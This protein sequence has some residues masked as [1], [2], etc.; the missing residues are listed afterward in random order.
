[1]R[2]GIVNVK[3]DTMA[4]LFQAAGPHREDIL[5]DITLDAGILWHCGACDNDNTEESGACENCGS[6][7]GSEEV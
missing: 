3:A 2:G 5:R 1:M 6:A 7:P 4:R